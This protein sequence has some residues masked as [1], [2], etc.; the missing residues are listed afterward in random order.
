V[1]PIASTLE[2]VVASSVRRANAAKPNEGP[3]LAWPLA[4]GS[5]VAARTR[6]IEFRGAVL[7]VEVPDAGWRAELVHLA[8]RY[9]AAV[10]RYSSVPIDRIEFVVASSRVHNRVSSAGR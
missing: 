7:W 8:P 2:K 9:L 1:E 5:A 4:C 10:N 6:A 3:V